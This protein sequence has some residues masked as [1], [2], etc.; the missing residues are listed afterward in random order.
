VISQRHCPIPDDFGPHLDIN[1]GQT[2]ASVTVSGS[3]STIGEGG[4]YA[5][6]GNLTVW[7]NLNPDYPS[8][9]VTRLEPAKQGSELVSLGRDDVRRNATCD[10]EVQF[11][12]PR[13]ATGT[14]PVVVLEVAPD[15]STASGGFVMF[16]V[17]A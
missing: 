14:Y 3:Y 7:W 13:S 17:T 10:Y 2:G 15:G 5:P 9:G 8:Q 16:D 4:G 12:V 6:L 11:V 1:S